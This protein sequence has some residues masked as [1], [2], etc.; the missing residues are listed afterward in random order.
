MKH[1]NLLLRL[2]YILFLLMFVLACQFSYSLGGGDSTAEPAAAAADTLQPE[3]P[4]IPTSTEIPITA[5]PSP[6]PIGSIVQYNDLEITVLDVINRESVHF[7]DKS[8][9]GQWTY[10]YTPKAGD[11]IID[12]GVL[13]RNTDHSNAYQTQW[14]YIYVLESNGDGW[15]PSWGKVKSV[16]SDAKVDPFT[17]GLSSDPLQ[18]EDVVEFTGD[19]YMRLIYSVA[20]DP[21]QTILFGIEDSP[22]VSFNVPAR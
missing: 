13:V 14:Q 11:N 21:N 17:I 7:G 20:D 8:P 12:V 1:N 9:D 3:P 6:V 5:T 2:L 10:F 19:T 4:L 18:A 16:S 22:N 15:Y